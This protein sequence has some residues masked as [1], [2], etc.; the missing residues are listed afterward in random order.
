MYSNLL[1]VSLVLPLN[2]FHFQ[3]GSID[4]GLIISEWIVE[5]YIFLCHSPA[6]SYQEWDRLRQTV[7]TNTKRSHDRQLTDRWECRLTNTSSSTTD[8]ITPCTFS[9]T[10][11]ISVRVCSS[12]L[13]L[14]FNTCTHQHGFKHSIFKTGMGYTCLDSVLVTILHHFSYT[15]FNFFYSSYSFV[16]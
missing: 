3:C 11:T 7:H 13:D 1:K 16:S 2:Q 5:C 10:H 6:G 12:I 14:L 4:D 9:I 15:V 8:T